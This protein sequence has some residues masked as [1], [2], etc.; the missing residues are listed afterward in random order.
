MYITQLRE[1]TSELPV[2]IQPLTA[3]LFFTVVYGA[4]YLPVLFGHAS[5][6]TNASWPRGPLFVVDPIAGGQITVPLEKL[7]AN[8]WGH[9]RLPVVDP[10]QGYGIPLLATQGIP[11]F[12]PEI[13][14]I[15]CFLIPTPSGTYCA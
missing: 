7:A 6:K 15:S 2:W 4:I 5:L 9:L 12:P 8:A 13:M 14:S 10:Y 3:F 11:V 1:R